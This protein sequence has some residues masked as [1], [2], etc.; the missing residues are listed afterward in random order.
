MKNTIHII[1]LVISLALIGC[2][3]DSSKQ[4]A[5]EPQEKTYVVEAK[6]SSTSLY[7]SGT[8]EPIRIS[9]VSSPVEGVI[10]EKF[11]EY[12]QL[13]NEKQKMFGLNSDSLEKEFL[14]SISE[15]LKSVDNYADKERKYQGSE[16]L[17]KLGF[18][19]DNE[20]YSDKNQWEE[21][22]FSLRQSAKNV[23]ETVAKLG[24]KRDL[25]TIN[26]KD[27]A[28]IDRII[29][30]KLENI[31]VHAKRDGVA[32]LPMKK[33]EDKSEG[34]IG[35]GSEVKAGQVLV[36]IGD[37][38][39][40]AVDVEVNELDINQ[41]E[42]GQEATITGTGF[43]GIS[44]HGKVSEIHGQAKSSGSSLPTFPITVIVPEISKDQQEI[45]HVGMSA[46][47]QISI[48]EPEQIMVPL[49][50]VFQE[51]GR[52]MVKVK[53]KESGEVKKVPV[54]IGKTSAD[55]IVIEHG[56]NVGDVIV[57]NN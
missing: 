35:V 4:A 21:A 31:K 7:F 56:I 11:F 37:M 32:L 39:G 28:T 54:V 18:I 1:I 15:Y 47:V 42:K 25:S 50:A 33:G 40:V 38:S 29:A 14:T 41:I 12:G 48:T 22:Y 45:I 36:S 5:E 52:S 13:I 23:K 43:P 9:N 20:Y 24:I 16:E 34:A 55:E 10:R 3:Q 53:D 26:L 57:Y 8:I 44:L 51:E 19:S 27:R 46:K 49:D 6:P 2:S 30:Y 17:W